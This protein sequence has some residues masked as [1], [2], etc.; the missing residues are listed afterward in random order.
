MPV[1]PRFS[2]LVK[3]PDREKRKAAIQALA[4]TKDRDAIPYLEHIEDFDTDAELRDLAKKAITY[5]DRNNPENFRAVPEQDD[6]PHASPIMPETR[7]APDAG[8]TPDAVQLTPFSPE[9]TISPR[10]EKLARSVL[11]GAV[12][13]NMQGKKLLAAKAI[14]QAFKINPN[15]ARDSYAISI[16]RD[17]TQDY[18]NDAIEMA[19][20]GTLIDLYDPKKTKGKRGAGGGDGGAVVADDDQE[21]SS[22]G[23][24]ADLLIY[25]IIS[26]LVGIGIQLYLVFVYFPNLPTFIQSAFNSG[27]GLTFQQAL[28]Q[29]QALNLGDTNNLILGGISAALS[30]LLSQLIY[31][32]AIN[33]AANQFL[34]GD[35]TFNGVLQRLS[36]LGSIF[37]I[38]LGVVVIG[39]MALTQNSTSP[40]QFVSVFNLTGIAL[41]VLSFVYLI[42]LAWQIGKNYRFGAFKG[43][44]SVIVGGVLLFAIACFL[45]LALSFATASAITG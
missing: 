22:T 6:K 45:T 35:G 8:S 18:S 26:T 33:W 30:T 28:A 21:P 11:E 27:D 31:C 14:V 39:A 2:D 29:V 43:C 1:D 5:I 17:V 16:I 19:K 25:T 20:N 38:V 9:R 42:A 32:F 12:S 3:N 41:L 24:L 15:L 13:N 23:A 40:D 44:L 37:N 36:N 34:G 4:R 7:S 10:E